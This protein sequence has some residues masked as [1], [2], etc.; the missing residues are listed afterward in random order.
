M[1]KAIL[2]ATAALMMTTAGGAWLQA[3]QVNSASVEALAG[4]FRLS[5]SQE[6]DL[7]RAYRGA[8]N[9]GIASQRL[10]GLIAHALEDEVEVRYV[11]RALALVTNTALNGLPV[12]PVLN[13]LGEGL[14]KKVGGRELV[15]AVES[16]ALS[17]K[18]A[19]QIVSVL[20]Y[21]ENSLGELEMVLISAANA[22]ERGVDEDAIKEIF[23]Q[24][25][26]DLK[27][28]M[29]GIEKLE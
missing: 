23:R 16:R 15:E 20:I 28:V 1:R 2:A 29:A 27:R 24:E 13:K 12:S 17:L 5:R 18:K 7:L 14:A 9:V 25:G 10:E 8:V 21:E 19:R 11:V 22:L 6:D 26:P 3:A 4:K